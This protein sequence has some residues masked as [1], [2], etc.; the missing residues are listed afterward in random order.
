MSKQFDPLESWVIS[1]IP[2]GRSEGK[3]PSHIPGQRYQIPLAFDLV[4]SVQGELP[5]PITDLMIPNTG[6]GICLRRAYNRLPSFLAN[7]CAIASSG[8]GFPAA[9]LL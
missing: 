2:S 1:P 4:Q 8:E 3:H 6:S 5:E 9:G 7:R